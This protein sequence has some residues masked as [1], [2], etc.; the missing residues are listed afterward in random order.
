MKN[1]LINK[2]FFP[3]KLAEYNK[4]VNNNK[5]IVGWFPQLE[6]DLQES[7]TLEDLMN[8]HKHAWDLGYQNKNI[9]PCPW[10]MFRTSSI[11]EMTINDVYL[12]G[13]WGLTTNPIPFWEE[14]KEET[15]AGNGFG[16]DD[17]KKIYDLIMSQYRNHLRS[18]FVAIKNYS[19]SWLETHEM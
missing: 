5:A 1:N 8:V 4:K 10:G 3:K 18:N 7:K 19:R 6:Q 2:L 16:I 12:G 14:N 17:N 11:P 15:M 13:I 9:V